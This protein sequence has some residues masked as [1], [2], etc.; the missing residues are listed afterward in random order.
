MGLGIPAVSVE[1]ISFSYQEKP[2]FTGCSLEIP[3][4]RFSVILGRNGSG[5]STLL[6][7]LSGLL[8]PSAGTLLI[9]GTSH[10][11]LSGKEKSR[12]I[13]YLPQFH[14]PVFPFTVREVVLTGR[15]GQAGFSPSAEDAELAESAIRDLDIGHLA[16]KQF[17][18]LSGGEQQLVM[19]ARVLAQ[20]PAVLFLDE[21]T[22]HL[23]LIFQNHLLSR[24]KSLST[25]QFSIVAVLHDLNLA[26]V[27]GDHFY[28]VTGGKVLD[29]GSRETSFSPA[30]LQT[31]FGIPFRVFKDGDRVLVFPDFNNGEQKVHF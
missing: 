11:D 6:K 16:D 4:H 14:Q 13:G 22:A 3:S 25:G 20:K 2:V 7:L 24:L 28:F 27:W 30:F 18:R 29:G 8:Q 19:A 21:P 23:D 1:N 26:S 12:R 5:K 31:C 10:S 9:H 15:T 17:T